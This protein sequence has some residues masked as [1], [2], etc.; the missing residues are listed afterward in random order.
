MS[1]QV[2]NN[3]SVNRNHRD[4]EN[5]DLRESLMRNMA[6]NPEGYALIEDEN[7]SARSFAHQ[8]YVGAL[9]LTWWTLTIGYNI[10]NKKV[11]LHCQL[12]WIFAVG[13]MFAGVPVNL[14]LWGTGMRK[15]PQLS[16]QELMMIVPVALCHCLTHIGGVVSM[17]AGA[18]SFTHIVKS[19]E[20]VFSSIF[21]G[22][23][24]GKFFSW[25]VYAALI[26]IIAGV[27]FASA[28]K[29]IGFTMLAF[30]SALVSN[31]FSALR[32]VIAKKTMGKDAFRAEQN[33]TASNIY[34]VMTIL[35]FFLLLPVSFLVE[36]NV[37]ADE[38]NR[39][40]TDGEGYSTMQLFL[41][42]SASAM[43]YYVYNEVAFLVLDNVHPVTH[44]VG[45]TI[46][47]VA[48]IGFAIF[49]FNPP[50]STNGYIGSAIAIA[51]TFL[52][53]AAVKTYKTTY[54]IQLVPNVASK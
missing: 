50:M 36:W 25:Q 19:S 7:S 24:L 6:D 53:S 41:E 1:A 35:S 34:A 18:I 30:G 22:V 12:P 40:L 42:L 44:S 43:F 54:K 20:P 3:N 9:F 38:W 4:V 28:S 37:M 45:N 49:I 47:R 31:T 51:G 5:Q 39:H 10:Y 16:R 15:F 32:G 29:N 8:L 17:G 46:K 11:L 27:G 48:V 2:A 13:Q 14:F 23:M 52:Y 21:A 26:P 33:M